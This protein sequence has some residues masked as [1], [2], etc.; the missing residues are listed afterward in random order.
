MTKVVFLWL[1][2]WC[3]LYLLMITSYSK[4]TWMFPATGVLPSEDTGEQC[5]PVESENILDSWTLQGILWVVGAW[6][7]YL[8]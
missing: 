7:T 3:G 8:W 4:E 5:S 6:E 1:S 2:L